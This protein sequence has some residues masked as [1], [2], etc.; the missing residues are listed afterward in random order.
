MNF[1]SNATA[2]AVGQGAPEKTQ[3]IKS[4]DNTHQQNEE[5]KS[6]HWPDP[7]PLV[8]KLP[9]APPLDAHA[10]LPKVLADFVLDGADRMPCPPDFVAASLIVNLASVIGAGCAIKPKRRDDWI[11][12][13]NL[14][15]GIVGDPSTKKSPAMGI[16]SRFL[17]HLE[18]LEEGNLFHQKKD[19]EAQKA[20]F[21]ARQESL[22]KQMK[23]AASSKNSD[24]DMLDA[25]NAMASLEEPQ[26]P[27]RR[28][29]KTN[30]STVA[31]LG[32]MLANNPQGLLVFRDEIMG[33]LNSWEIPGHESDRAFYLEGWNGIGSHL[34]DRIARGSLTIPNHCLS[35][36]GG[37][38]PDLLQRYLATI[39]HSTDNDG[40]IQRFQVLVY[41][42]SVPWEWRDRYPINGSREAV[43]DI[44]F[45]L[46]YFDP[47]QYGARPADEL[48]KLPYFSFDD[49]AQEHFIEWTS[50]LHTKLIPDE[51]TPLM[52]QHLG[53][54]D[55]LFCALALVLHLAEG[56][57]GPIKL[58]S[59]QRAAAWCKYLEGHARR[60]YE[61][62]EVA[63]V[64]TAKIL[65][66]RIAK[67]KLKDEFTVR[68]VV[69]KQWG[70]LT[71]N[72]QV[73]AAL[74]VL[75]E[76]HWV[77]A[78]DDID[79]LVGRPTT[80]YFINPKTQKVVP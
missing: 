20:A 9:P 34:L 62:L 26:E 17:D 54:F 60:V 32:E 5:R 1:L 63:K 56:N 3:E 4:V 46:A 41:P 49:A 55:K 16:T 25:V 44:F 47:V 19:F 8:I 40:R 29:F 80:R 31:K 59:T 48:F 76:A 71:T 77:L 67:G 65:A 61:L 73:E 75:E 36:F 69:R 21:E 53:K 79:K 45:R 7:A 39:A 51:L 18:K 10:L 70:G 6:Y 23:K 13:P 66:S 15:G 52:A 50:E 72:I 38:Q 58:E 24:S 74:A 42:D 22:H 14:W 57:T 68:D 64:S 78:L 11:L 30:D 43:R 33:L 2:V 35:I 27:Q 37:I 28:R 12:T